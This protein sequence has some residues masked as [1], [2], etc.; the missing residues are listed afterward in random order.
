MNDECIVVHRSSFSCG[1]FMLTNPP[2]VV[3]RRRG[4]EKQQAS[5][6]PG[7]VGALTLVAAS[8]DPDA[9]TITLT[10]DRAIDVSG[11]VGSKIVV[12][13]GSI[14]AAV[15]GATGAVEQ[16]DAASVVIGL[17]YLSDDSEPQVLLNAATGNGIVAV[18]DGH[19]WAGVTDLVLPFP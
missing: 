1:V 17:F 4:R 7:P 10:F 8:Y 9:Q 3:R 18:G 11:L 5:P 19:A 13:D 12:V 16:P 2:A 15:Y 14:T 6:A